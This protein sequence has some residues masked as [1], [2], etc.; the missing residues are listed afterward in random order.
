MRIVLY[1]EG[2]TERSL[3]EF[4]AKWLNPKLQEA[5]QIRPVVF[6]GV[7]NY[8]KDFSK[9]AKLDLSV[10]FTRR[11]SMLAPRRQRCGD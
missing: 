4:L 9:R 10:R 8:L 2:D 11:E 1:V 5:I 6:H 7:G 3:P